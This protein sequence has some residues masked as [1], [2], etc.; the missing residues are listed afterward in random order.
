MIFPRHMLG[1]RITRALGALLRRVPALIA[2]LALM[3]QLGSC[4]HVALVEHVRCAEHGEW[5]HADTHARPAPG[6]DGEHSGAP[7]AATLR[8]GA[9]PHAHDHCSVSVDRR[10][11]TQPDSAWSLVLA[12]ESAAESQERSAFVPGGTACVY[13]YAPKN[14]P[15]HAVG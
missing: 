10:E 9:E 7:I 8:E 1:R 3:A 2:L 6:S 15:P 14:S 4:L 11:L 13:G 12:A 5:E